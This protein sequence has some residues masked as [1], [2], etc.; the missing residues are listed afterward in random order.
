ME[1]HWIV[2]GQG[3]TQT[4][5]QKLSEGVFGVFQ[6]KTVVAQWRHCNWHLGQVV[7]VLQYRAL[8]ENT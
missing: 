2:S 8:K 3:H 6:E 7:Q 5:L 4:F 1:L